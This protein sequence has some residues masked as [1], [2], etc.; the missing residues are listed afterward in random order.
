MWTIIFH[1]R[2]GEPPHK[3]Y[4]ATREEAMHAFRRAWEAGSGKDFAWRAR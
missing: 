1:E 4:A 2:R 3:G